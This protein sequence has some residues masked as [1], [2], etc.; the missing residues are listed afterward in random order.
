MGLLDDIVHLPNKAIGVATFRKTRHRYSD[1]ASAF[2]RDAQD[3]SDQWMEESEKWRP[4]V[5]KAIH[6]GEKWRPIA[7]EFNK[8][9]ARGNRNAEYGLLESVRWRR[10]LR[11]YSWMGVTLATIIAA[12]YGH[13]MA[14]RPRITDAVANTWGVGTCGTVLYGGCWVWELRQEEKELSQRISKFSQKLWLDDPSDYRNRG[15]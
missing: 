14:I 11:K 3:I 1:E 8:N 15:I 2:R 4:F 10:D 7:D 6:E 5:E 9:L 13:R 12:G